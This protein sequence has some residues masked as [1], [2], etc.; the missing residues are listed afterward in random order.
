MIR[1]CKITGRIRTGCVFLLLLF[2]PLELNAQQRFP[3]ANLAGERPNIILIMADDLGYSDLGAYGSR[4]DTPTLDRLANQGLHLSNYYNMAKC[5]PTR[6]TL[7]NGMFTKKEPYENVRTLPQ[8]L[9]DAGYYTAIS[10]KEHFSDWFPDRHYAN[11][12]F[13]DSFVYQAINPYWAPDEGEEFPYP[14]KLNGDVVDV[15]KNT[16]RDEFYKTD[17]VTEYGLQFLENGAKTDK[18]FFLY[19][20]YHLPHY[21]LQAREKLI[22]KYRGDFLDGW[23]QLR[24]KRFERQKASG[25]LPE[26]ATLS[27]PESNIYPHNG[28]EKWHKYDP[29]NEISEERKDQLDREFATYAAMVD[30][31]DQQVAKLM[32]R[33]KELNEHENTL[34]L[35]MSDNGA[36][37]FDNGRNTGHGDPKFGARG[38]YNYQR[39]EWASVANTPFRYFKLYGHEG[40]SRAPFI[41]YWPGKIEPNL[42]HQPASVADLYPTLLDLAGASGPSGDGSDPE[43]S[44]DGRSLLPVFNGKTFDEPRFIVSGLSSNLRMVR[45]GDWKI[46]RV[47]GRAWE[48]YN[49]AK[50]PAETNNLADEHPEKVNEIKQRFENWKREENAVFFR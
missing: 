16:P 23:D 24:R 43:P 36:C 46:V 29:W 15:L 25:L 44:T 48:L 13:D 49:L 42:S 9:G 50:D 45:Y 4:F 31:L 35:F 20:P 47:K 30:E 38:S 26:H 41:A 34:V 2:T 12:T 21:P 39:P 8:V 11:R 6:E 37:P 1:F 32:D 17:V 40:G 27:A 10:G 3:E 18:P 7:M 33:L 5:N 28:S 22:Q 14:F 19:M